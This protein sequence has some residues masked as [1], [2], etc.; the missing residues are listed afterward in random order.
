MELEFSSLN[1]HFIPQLTNHDNNHVFRFDKLHSSATWLRCLRAGDDA[2]G[3]AASHADGQLAVPRG[4]AAAAFRLS[5]QP[6]VWC[7]DAHGA[8][9]RTPRSAGNTCLQ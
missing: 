3:E 7:L 2:R 1:F 9:W 4:L 6:P 8:G 5:D